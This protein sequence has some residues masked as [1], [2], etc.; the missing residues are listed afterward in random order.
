MDPFQLELLGFV[1]GATTLTSSVPQLLAN[2]RNPN[3]A[4]GQ[5]PTRNILQ[6]SGNALWLVYGM[7]I[8]SL[9]MATFASLGMI[10]AGLL[11]YQTFMGRHRALG[12]EN[13]ALA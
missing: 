12:N 4:C 3:L 7:M 10:M 11:A 9:A 1:A 2:L 13:A 6:C 5:S 8:G